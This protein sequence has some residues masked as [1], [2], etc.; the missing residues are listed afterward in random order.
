MH[1]GMLRV[2]SEI[3]RGN[4]AEAVPVYV[5]A[6]RK[7]CVFYCYKVKESGPANIIAG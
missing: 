7:V 6:D 1:A 4:N 2:M 3:W 5:K